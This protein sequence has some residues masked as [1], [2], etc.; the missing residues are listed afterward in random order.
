MLRKRVKKVKFDVVKRQK[1]GPSAEIV[2]KASGSRKFRAHTVQTRRN[3][4]SKLYE[5]ED[6]ESE[7]LI[8]P[9]LMNTRAGK[10]PKSFF[11]LKSGYSS[12]VE[13]PQ[14]INLLEEPKPLKKRIATP[15]R[16]VIA[17]V[18][19]PAAHFK[20]AD[21]PSRVTRGANPVKKII[22]PTK[23]Q[24]S[25]DKIEVHSPFRYPKSTTLKLKVPC[26]EEK[27]NRKDRYRNKK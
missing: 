15:A 11:A 26:K 21:A 5:I 9:I 6:P 19:T 1:V 7:P 18:G 3:T 23:K 13:Q 22:V 20:K 14:T 24:F 17:R 8:K 12:E 27:H 4:E 25:D 16:R 2:I 10:K